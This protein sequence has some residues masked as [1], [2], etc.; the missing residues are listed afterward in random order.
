[1]PLKEVTVLGKSERDPAAESE[2]GVKTVVTT[3]I[4][5]QVWPS[6]VITTNHMFVLFKK[7]FL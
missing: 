7:I 6:N 2:T 3:I 5:I 4:K 1:M